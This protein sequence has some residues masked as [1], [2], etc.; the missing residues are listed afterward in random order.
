[1]T[2]HVASHNLSGAVPV[3]TG[4]RQDA[5]IVAAHRKLYRQVLSAFDAARARVTLANFTL[6]A[7][8]YKAW[9]A[10]VN[11]SK[12]HE[13]A[14]LHTAVNAVV[15]TLGAYMLVAI[16]SAAQKAYVDEVARLAA[17]RAPGANIRKDVTV[18]YSG[19]NS[20][21]MNQLTY[22]QTQLI[23]ELSVEQRQQVLD[24]LQR[25]VAAGRNPRDIARDIRANIGL[26]RRQQEIVDRYRTTLEN[27]HVDPRSAANALGRQLRDKRFD[28]PVR[29]RVAL[30]PAK[31]DQMVERYRQRWLAYRAENI[32]RTE[33][34]RAVHA[35]EAVAWHEAV[36]A[37]KIK[38]QQIRQRWVTCRDAQVRDSHA[39]M[40]GQVRPWGV[41]FNSGLGNL[42]MFPGDFGAPPADVCFC[43]CVVVRTLEP[44]P[45]D[46]A[47]NAASM[48]DQ[49]AAARGGIAAEAE[50]EAESAGALSDAEAT[51]TAAETETEVAGS[52]AEA[53]AEAGGEVASE[54]GADWAETE[55]GA[56]SDAESEAQLDIYDAQAAAEAENFGVLATAY[57]AV[58]A[59]APEI[60]TAGLD[61]A[62]RRR[63]IILLRE[64]LRRGQPLRAAEIRD[65]S[66]DLIGAASQRSK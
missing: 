44:S 46:V 26:T 45:I 50:A 21:A 32:A 48:T 19:V 30:T 8:D 5:A 55:V 40:E 10:A 9:L 35:G 64:A 28:S 25:G 38:P 36:S 16:S 37:G 52:E 51:A 7:G 42:L 54:G 14:S 49:S 1:M 57:N 41:P 56:A 62:S 61:V 29:R 3:D 66:P 23:R 4:A 15:E 22:E 34:L 27:A 53:E 58:F 31:I 12:H 2:A 65:I 59:D 63:A 33:A 47:A 13:F 6:L 43:R 11:D 18:S 60:R 20:R 24:A 39:F 17:L